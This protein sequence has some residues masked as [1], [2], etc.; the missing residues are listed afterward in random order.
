M[1]LTQ[2]L[3][4]RALDRVVLEAAVYANADPLGNAAA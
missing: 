3:L 2:Q 4:V 1:S